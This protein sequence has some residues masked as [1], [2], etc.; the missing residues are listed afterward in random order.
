M[1]RLNTAPVCIKQGGDFLNNV[2][3]IMILFITRFDLPF[4]KAGFWRVFCSGEVKVMMKNRFLGLLAALLFVFVHVHFSYAEPQVVS[5]TGVAPFSAGDEAK[6]RDMAI[7]DAMRKAVEQAVGTM[8]A[9]ETA[10]ENYQLIRE[11]VLTKTQGYIQKYDVVSAGAKGNLYE[12][13]ISATVAVENLKND[14]AALGLLHAQVEKPRVL[15]MIAEQNIGQEYIFWWGWWGDVKAVGQHVDMTAS[16]TALKEEFINK[17]FN[18]VDASAVTGKIEISNAYRMAD[19]TD[20]GAKE[21]GRKL[22]AEVVIKGKAMAKEG[23][24][25][26]GSNVGSYLADIT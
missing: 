20:V 26:S 1:F 24:R 21:I 19:L 4:K 25:T 16:E 14:L 10:V 15:F 13:T 2:Y 5:A 3:S 7:Q 9:A 12:V 8:V 22:G 6:A 17:G 18:I 11:S 23:P